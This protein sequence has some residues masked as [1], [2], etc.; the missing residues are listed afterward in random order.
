MIKKIFFLIKTLSKY[1]K[2]IFK[3]SFYEIFFSIRMGRNYYKIYN[4]ALQADSLPC[5]YYF[6]YKISKFVKK[7]QI[8]KVIDLGS[9]NGRVV[10]FLSTKTNAK[11]KGFEKDKEIYNYSIKNLN[12]NAEIKLEDIN[13][14]D[15]SNL[16]ANCYILN[17]P[18]W[19]ELI[20]KNLI[21]K[22]FSSNM[23]KAEK[24]YIIII[25]T[26]VIL[27]KISLDRLFE[28]FKLIKFINAGP[29]RSLRI[30]ESK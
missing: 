18:F 14:I 21:D 26:D 20:L 11:V 10:N 7:N 27:K 12:E 9:G 25:N 30:Y 29:I 5:P 13:L 28:N 3:V 2:K 19:Q 17:T 6:I 22:I 24:Y 15:Y 8:N 4:D 1:R 16:N 23:S